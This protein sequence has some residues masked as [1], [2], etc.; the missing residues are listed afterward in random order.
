[1]IPS[2]AEIIAG[3]V[4]GKYSAELAEQWIN[5]HIDLAG[6]PDD[7]L[8]DHFAGLAMQAIRGDGQFLLRHEPD[9]VADRAYE[10]ADSMLKARA[11]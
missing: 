2:I 5:Q 7:D 9:Q 10:Q 11:A 4:A 3:L 8:R 1:M 6:T